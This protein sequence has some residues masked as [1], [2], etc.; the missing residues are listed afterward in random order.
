MMI[1]PPT[2]VPRVMTKAGVTPRAAPWQ[3]SPHAAALA[4][5]STTTGRSNWASSWA[6][7]GTLISFGMFGA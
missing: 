4:S 1:P 2:P 6:R 7:S 5:L 3:A